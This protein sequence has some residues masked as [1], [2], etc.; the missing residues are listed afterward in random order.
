MRSWGGSVR[1]EQNLV[2]DVG[3]ETIA[4][5]CGHAN[6]AT[7]NI[8]AAGQQCRGTSCSPHAYLYGCEFGQPN[9]F[10]FTKNV[11]YMAAP[12]DNLF[13][14]YAIYGNATYA[15][16]LYYSENSDHELNFPNVAQ[17]ATNLTFAEWQATGQDKGSVQGDPR[18]VDFAARNFAL[19]PD[20]PLHAM[21]FVPIDAS[22]AGPRL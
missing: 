1:W 17:N 6:V 11:V 2:H 13:V 18:F 19:R 15:D 5:H 10:D 16:N 22:A 4:L 9:E 20:S 3:D 14:S 21:G 7:N 8:L 12:E